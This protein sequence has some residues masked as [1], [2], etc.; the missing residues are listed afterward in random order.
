MK[1]ALKRVLY[2]LRKFTGKFVLLPCDIDGINFD[3][4]VYKAAHIIAADKIEGDY[5][6]FGV[7]TGTSFIHS[8]KAIK[9][10]FELFKMPHGGEKEND[11]IERHELLGKKRFFAFD[12]FQ[13][14]PELEDVDKETR[15]FAKGKFTCS[16]SEFRGNLIKAGIPLENVVI[17]PGWFEQT[18]TMQTIKKYGM[19]KAAIIHIDC[20]L[21]ASTKTALNFVKPLLTDGTIIIFDD[22]YCFRGDPNL[23]EQKAFYEWRETTKDWMFTEYQKEGPWRNSFIVNRKA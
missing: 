8:Y 22:W 11:C 10:V 9:K 20:D 23:G 12:S 3:S 19:E 18:C 21:Y 13:G 4:I 5:L 14:L 17:I 1:Q 2:P 6:E 15:D 7:Y 16:E